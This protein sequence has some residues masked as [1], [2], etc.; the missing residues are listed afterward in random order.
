M[1]SKAP[2]HSQIKENHIGMHNTWNFYVDVAG[3]H[4]QKDTS[5]SEESVATVD[6]GSGQATFFSCP[7]FMI[8]LFV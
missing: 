5:A 4:L 2:R 1:D 8:L 3:L 7:V 6:T